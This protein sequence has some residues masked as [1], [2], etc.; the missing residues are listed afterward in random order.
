[1]AKFSEENF[2]AGV[3]PHLQPGER[4]L[5]VAY[6]VKQPG[7]FL[8][9]LLFATIG[10]ALAVGALTKHYLLALTDRRLLIVQVQGGLFGVSFA[11]KA[12][13]EYSFSQLASLPLKTSTGGL[14]THVRI[15]APQ[16]FIAK[17]HRLATKTNREH[18]TGIA[19]A[20]EAIKRGGAPQLA[21]PGYGAPPGGYGAPQL[22]QG[23]GGYGAPLPSQGQGGYGAPPAGQGPGGYGAPQPNQGQ[24]GYGAPPYGQAQQHAG[25]YGQPPQAGYGQAPQAGHGGPPQGGYG[26]Q[27]QAYGG[28]PQ[29]GYGGP[30]QAYG[31]PPQAHG[32]GQGPGQG[33][34]PWGPSL[35]AKRG[36][37]LGPFVRGRRCVRGPRRAR[38]RAG[39]PGGGGGVMGMAHG[40]G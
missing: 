15:D 13:T 9:L 11:T 21:P 37:A 31:G 40:N 16:P 24:G 38:D 33:G 26:G 6:G 2:R 28:P 27:P 17:F 8:M 39:A 22:G 10:G 20:L 4:L 35:A 19:Q 34:A 3:Q 18:A 14:F 30:P 32:Q 36:R 25:G 12:L 7:F 5:H 29:G 23:Q 1:M